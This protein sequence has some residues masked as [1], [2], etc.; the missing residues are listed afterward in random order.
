M[1]AWDFVTKPYDAKVLLSR[2]RNAIARSQI[3]AYK[4]LQ[5]MAE[6]DQLTGLYNRGK[7]FS[8]T[9]NL[10][11]DNP[12]MNFAF[13][14][15]DIDHF[16]LF[17][18]SFG[19]KEGDKLLKFLADCI[20]YN[21]KDSSLCVYGRMNA[22]VFC[23]CFPYIGKPK[24]LT[25]RVD[26]MQEY[27]SNYRQDYRLEVSVGICLIDDS[28]LNV[29][30]FYFRA[31]LASLQCKNQVEKHYSFYDNKAGDL[32]AKEIIITNEMQ[33]ALDEGQ[34]VVYLQPKF[35]L[36]TETPCGAE[37]LVRWI[38]PTKGLISPG[39]FIPAL[40]EMGSFQK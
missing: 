32:M 1:G 17:N 2:L 21:A 36:S 30:E 27:L 16:A 37:A 31:S 38:H 40:K 23:A 24:N 39:D 35:K 8:E 22:D 15:I 5:H 4:K 9:R 29:D 26:K 11:D 3:S 25:K 28:S 10:L 33:N 13:V 12:D 19:E 20:I 34:F 14:R 6:Y 7:M 18:T